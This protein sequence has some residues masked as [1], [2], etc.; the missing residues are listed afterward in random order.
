MLPWGDALRRVWLPR[1]HE[2]VGN[3]RLTD[4]IRH[5]IN[6]SSFQVYVAPTTSGFI[7]NY[8]DEM[9]VCDAFASETA[10]FSR[11]AAETSSTITDVSRLPSSRAWQLIQWYYAA[12]YAA[13]ALLRMCGIGLTYLEKGHASTIE[14]VS[15]L[16]GHPAALVT[17]GFYIVTQAPLNPTYG[18]GLKFD[19]I[20]HSKGSHDELWTLFVNF[21]D[22]RAGDVL[23]NQRLP[24]REAQ[25]IS[26]EIS[27]L[28]RLLRRAP[29]LNGT[30][31]SSIRND[32]TYRHTRSAWHPWRPV[33]GL[34]SLREKYP[35]DMSDVSAQIA[36]AVGGASDLQ[37]FRYAC[38]S[39]VA[40]CRVS[41]RE[42][43]TRCPLGR[44]KSFQAG[45]LAALDQLVA[46]R[47]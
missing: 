34:P 14:E 8:S 3:P 32:V 31:L 46:Q 30:W 43:I 41:C 16:Y 28:A 37:R 21:L 47:S 35:E 18:R 6:E 42:M 44:R 39:I 11:A 20:V 9:L 4:G 7:L 12:F 13:H 23:S 25:Q 15:Q 24:Q 22:A 27:A 5:W 36:L 40:L 10:R 38:Y 2:V 19:K 26:N 45:A 1:L 17:S 33:N 29:H